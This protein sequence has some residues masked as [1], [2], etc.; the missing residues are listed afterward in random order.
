MNEPGLVS[1]LD[2]AVQLDCSHAPVARQGG[3]VQEDGRNQSSAELYLQRA[4]AG[5]IV[6]FD[7]SPAEAADNAPAM[8]LCKFTD[9]LFRHVPENPQLRRLGDDIF[10]AY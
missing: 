10:G 4:H 7:L 5:I 2:A 6:E 1:Q 3:L 8:A 9:F